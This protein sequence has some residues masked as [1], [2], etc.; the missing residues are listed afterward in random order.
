MIYKKRIL[1]YVRMKRSQ[2]ETP[3]LFN[4]PRSTI[5]ILELLSL[6]TI[7]F[8][9]PAPKNNQKSKVG[10]VAPATK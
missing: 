8:A 10:R 6:L 2:Q 5:F 4:S 3:G 9:C 1:E 7:K